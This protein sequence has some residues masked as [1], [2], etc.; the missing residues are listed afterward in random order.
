MKQPMKLS[1]LLTGFSSAFVIALA[2]TVSSFSASAETA[3]EA[4]ARSG[5]GRAL[6]AAAQSVGLGEVLQTSDNLLILIPA[7]EQLTKLVD[8]EAT[9]VRRILEAHVFVNPKDQAYIDVYNSVDGRIRF[10]KFGMRGILQRA[11]SVGDSGCARIF[12]EDFKTGKPLYLD[13]SARGQLFFIQD[14]VVTVN[15]CE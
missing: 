15:V 13:Y 12:Y 14:Q 9:Q 2:V 7:K 3:A 5:D 1:N 6:L 8:L 11:D 4:L 10:L